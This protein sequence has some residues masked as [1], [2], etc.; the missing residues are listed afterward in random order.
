MLFVTFGLSSACI[1]DSVPF[2]CYEFCFAVLIASCC[3]VSVNN[4]EN[5]DDSE[6]IVILN[7][8]ITL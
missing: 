5:H 4:L 1:I 7:L 6:Y 3:N 2:H 8:G